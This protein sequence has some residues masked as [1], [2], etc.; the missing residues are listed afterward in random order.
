MPLR[1]IFPRSVLDNDELVRVY[2]TARTTDLDILRQTAAELFPER[3]QE[4]LTPEEQALSAGQEEEH[5]SCL[6]MVQSY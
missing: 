3:F 4:G 6:G 5:E 1:S 2:Q